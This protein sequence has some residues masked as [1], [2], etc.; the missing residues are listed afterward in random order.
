MGYSYEFATEQD[1]EEISRLLED[2]EFKGE[3]SIAYCRRPN[4]VLSLAKDG[5]K[6]TFV[7]AKDNDGKIVGVGACVIKGD[8][9]YL[10]GLRAIR[11]TNIPKC[12]EMLR[13]F[14]AQNNVRLTYTT[15]LSDNISVQTMLEKKRANMPYYLRH[16]EWVVN[17]IRKNLKIKDKNRLVKSGGGYVLENPHGEELARGKVVE[18]WDYKQYVVKR[19]GWKLKLAKRFF[20]WMPNEN[21]V[22]KFF[23]L[24]EVAAKDNTALE[25]FLRHTSRLPLEG[26]FFLYGGAFCPVKSIKYKSIVYIVDWDKTI[27]DVSNIQLNVEISDL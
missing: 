23:T 25:S 21:E 27:E 4:A 8:I 17:I 7:I 12:Y 26:N 11:R 16:S 2:V 18:Q 14:C 5:D 10:T 13:G 1:G 20:K 6:S 3:I 15:I 22:L 24:R 19:Y 9:A